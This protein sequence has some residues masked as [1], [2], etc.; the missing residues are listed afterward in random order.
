MLS[1]LAISLAID[2][3]GPICDNAG[4]IVEMCE[5]GNNVRQ[6]TDALDSA[7]NT[8]AAIGKGFA[9]GSAALV[10]LSL[11]GAFIT[12]VRDYHQSIQILDEFVFT[13]LL[14]G[15]MLPYWFSGI[16]LKT[17]G[18]AAMDMVREVRRQLEDPE[19][20]S[21]IK[22]A[23]FRQCIRISSESSL[24]QMIKP[25]MLVICTPIIFGVCFGVKSVCG[26]LPGAIISS[27]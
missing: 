18:V 3:F 15:A 14:I 11:Y 7:G 2:A 19:I 4:G 5:L 26:L 17:V 24:Y 16:T 9:I 13:S 10:S 1:N 23:D 25:G 22:P 12:R 8:T 20:K 27:V 21:G 6:I